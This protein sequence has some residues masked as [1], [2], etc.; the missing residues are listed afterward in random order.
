MSRIIVYYVVGPVHPRNLALIAREMPDWTFRVTYE[1]HIWWLNAQNM[2]KV[3][4]EKMALADH[5]VP[6][7]LWFGDVR[8]VIFSTVQPRQGPINLLRSAVERGVPTIA[9]QESNQIALNNGTINNYLLP[10]DHVLV[11]SSHERQGMIEAGVADRRVEVT[12]W[13]F[14]EGQIGKTA[15]DRLR[16]M[17][18]CL[19]LE[20]DRSVATLTLTSLNDAGESPAVRRRQLI[21]AA[22]GLPP[23]YQ[24]VVKPHPIEKLEVLMPFVTQCAPRA[25]VIEG[26][27]QIS[28]VLE[29]TDVLLNRGSSQVCIEALFR[30]IPVI[31]LDTGVQ[32]P[33]HGLAQDLIV[34]EPSDLVRALAW[35]SAQD[36]PMRV[37]VPFKEVHVPYSPLEA[38][39]L[40]CRRIADIAASSSHDP[41]RAGQW[42]DLALYQAWQLDRQIALEILSPACALDPDQPI[43]AL[44]QLIRFQATRADLDALK[45]YVGS[46]FRGHLL[47]CLWIDQLDQRHE[48]PMDADLEWMQAFPPPINTVWFVQHVSRWVD[49]LLRSGQSQAATALAQ[50]LDEEFAHVRGTTDLVRDVELYLTGVSGRA[51]YFLYRMMKQ[52]RATLRP[53]KRKL[54]KMAETRRKSVMRY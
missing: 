36:D 45:R 47:R 19:G 10:V 23:E 38:R 35:L 44:K 12:G 43:D 40:T 52:T 27:M 34:E 11:A 48:R 41:D 50:R 7:A 13:P 39:E 49:V 54:R 26:M 5:Q 46:G 21:L 33:F 17:K 18:E 30:E 51:K 1:P 6:D 4:F 3:P 2:A 24:L 28:D 9:I 53:V 29:A 25:K 16:A 42:F 22:Q 20:P 32:T 8:A 37:Y 31:I 15:P 14:Y